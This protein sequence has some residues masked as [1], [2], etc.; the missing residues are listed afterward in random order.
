MLSTL[1]LNPVWMALEAEF[2]LVSEARGERRVSAS[3]FFTGYRKTLLAD[4]EII[5]E[6]HVPLGRGEHDQYVRSFK[7]SQRRE[8]DIAIVTACMRASL[9]EDGVS[10]FEF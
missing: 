5:L 6:V 3:D 10:F 1:D 7:Q 9:A 4:D 8:D 2:V